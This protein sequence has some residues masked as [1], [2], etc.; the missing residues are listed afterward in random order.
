MTIL[1]RPCK[2]GKEKK[3]NNHGTTYV[4]NKRKATCL[5]I[6][7]WGFTHPHSGFR[8]LGHIRDR[9]YRDGAD[10]FRPSPDVQYVVILYKHVL[11]CI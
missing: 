10:L 5:I 2:A 7:P 8:A 1:R 11:Y 3:K 9:V 6:S 4:I